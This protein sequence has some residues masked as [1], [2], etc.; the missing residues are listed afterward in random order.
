MYL[1]RG[2]GNIETFNRKF[3]NQSMSGTIGNFDGLHLGHQAIL[4]QVKDKARESSSA[5]LV[6]FT[7]PHASEYFA[8]KDLKSSP[9]PRICPWREKV[10]LLKNFGIDFAFFLQ[11]NKSLKTMTP[12]TFLDE[13]LAQLKLKHLIIGDDFRFGAQ[14]AGDFELLKNWG[15]SNGSEVIANETVLLDGSRVSSTRIREALL[16]SDFQLAKKLLGRPYTFS[17]KV[18]YGQQLG[19]TIGVP[20]ANLWIP[21]QRL[22]IAGVYAVKCLL[23][24]KLLNGIANMGIR[25][26]V[27]GSKPV[28]EIHLFNFNESIYGQRLTVEFTNKLRD[29]KKFDNIDFLK[30][31]IL[32]DISQ[33]KLILE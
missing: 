33:A 16:K 20:T 1:I 31:Q 30:E 11:F 21:K 22:P 26:T 13:V 5:S 6:F 15:K 10:K 24:E 29:E 7:E 32:L 19:R 27:D 2:I 8:A 17:G 3:P 23:G 9:P 14:R 18:V 28:L 4:N 25:P 12:Q